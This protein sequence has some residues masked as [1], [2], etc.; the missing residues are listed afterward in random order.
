M[1]VLRKTLEI[2]TLL[3]FIAVAAI[4]VESHFIFVK[5]TGDS[6]SERNDQRIRINAYGK[7]TLSDNRNIEDT[8]NEKSMTMETSSR[9]KPIVGQRPLLVGTEIQNETFEEVKKES[10]NLPHST[11]NAATATKASLD[12]FHHQKGGMV[13]LYHVAK[14]GGTSIQQLFISMKKQKSSKRKYVYQKLGYKNRHVK[15]AFDDEEARDEQIRKIDDHIRGKNSK[16]LLMEVH[17]SHYGGLHNN[18]MLSS[19][20]RNWREMSQ[21]Y[22]TP[23]FVI[24]ILR[25]P[26]S[27]AKSYFRYFH[28]NCNKQWCPEQFNNTLEDFVQTLEIHPNHQCHMLIT[29]KIFRHRRNGETDSPFENEEECEAAYETMKSTVDFV[30]TTDA[31]TSELEPL[32]YHMLNGTVDEKHNLKSKEKLLFEETHT[33]DG[34]TM[35]RIEELSKYDQQIYDKVKRDFVLSDHFPDFKLKKKK[36]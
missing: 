2:L 1:G 6:P 22:K 7:N 34:T 23:M 25:E 13:L 14:T 36:G 28:V 10:V 8:L 18:S 16:T 17:S 21:A 9:I 24:T 12:M 3:S 35:A 20:I 29:E 27:F 4:M 33:I 19:K 26:F 11:T 15:I 5:L 32:L 31:L 30:G